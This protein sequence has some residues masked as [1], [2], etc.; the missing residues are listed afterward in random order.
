[1]PVVCQELVKYM[2]LDLMDKVS[3]HCITGKLAAMI[4]KT[5][6]EVDRLPEGSSCNANYI[7][8]GP[9]MT[10]LCAMVKTMGVKEMVLLQLESIVVLKLLRNTCV[11]DAHTG[12]NILTRA[13][14]KRLDSNVSIKVNK[15]ITET[16]END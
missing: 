7:G 6:N 2:Q 9:F 15:K 10:I 8:I 3:I 1:M 12:V 16:E 4:K 11:M 14:G 5:Q 13:Q